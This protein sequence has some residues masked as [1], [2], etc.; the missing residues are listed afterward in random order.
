L[1]AMSVAAI[2]RLS[3]GKVVA[4]KTLLGQTCEFVPRFPW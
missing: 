4:S 3:G 1:L 2:F